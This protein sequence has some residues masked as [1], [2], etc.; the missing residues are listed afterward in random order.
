MQSAVALQ[1]LITT[2]K[3]HPDISFKRQSIVAV[4]VVLNVGIKFIAIVLSLQD[5]L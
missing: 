2:V 1:L 5:S 4:A 3:H